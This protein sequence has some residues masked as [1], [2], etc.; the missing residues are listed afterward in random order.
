[1]LTAQPQS[2]FPAQL[3]YFSQ[4]MHFI[5]VGRKGGISSHALGGTAL[6]EE[7]PVC[8]RDVIEA[9]LVKQIKKM[10]LI[11]MLYG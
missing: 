9:C 3:K 10:K 1:M 2:F 8:M 4:G 5:I 7:F 6:K 11:S